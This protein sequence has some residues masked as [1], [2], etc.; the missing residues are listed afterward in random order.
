MNRDGSRIEKSLCGA[1]VQ[2]V[3]ETR[4]R[5]EALARDGAK[6]FMFDG[7][8]HNGECWD[9]EHGHRVPSGREEHVEATDRLARLIHTKYPDVLI[10]MHD[11]LCG[12]NPWRL[13]PRAGVSRRRRASNQPDLTRFGRSS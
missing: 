2:Y 8:M 1:S 6:F 7:T 5:L 10:E 12:G 13:T 9:P 4:S 3:E 11:M